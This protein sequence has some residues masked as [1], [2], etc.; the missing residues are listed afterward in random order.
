MTLYTAAITLILVMDPLGNIPIFINTLK[1]IDPNRQKII[2]L[3]ETLIAFLILTIFLFFGGSILHH[4]NIT[5]P[6]LS[7]SGGI[8][9]FL[10]TIKMIFPSEEN[11]SQER[12]VGEP[13]IVPL[14]IPLTAGPSAL[15][16]VLLFATQEPHKMGLWFVAVVIAATVFVIIMLL[17]RYIMKLLGSRGILA[18]ERLMGML[19]TTVAVEMLLHGLKLYFLSFSK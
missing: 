3:R 8:I 14:A 6:A 16:T 11:K 9:L 1:G 10:I 19:L 5:E 18:M 2:I 7:M 13:F 12:Y 15:A 17:S 4:L